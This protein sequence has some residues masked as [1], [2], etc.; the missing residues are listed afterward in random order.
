MGTGQ[1]KA[2]DGVLGSQGSRFQAPVK[3]FVKGFRQTESSVR[4]VGTNEDGHGGREREPP[5][6][7]KVRG[8]RR[9]TSG[10]I[11]ATRTR[12]KRY[13]ST[14]AWPLLVERGL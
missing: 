2:L 11:G 10:H 3:G 1:A 12:A 6:V 13:F 9:T 14:I 5:T 4:V 8:Y 7:E